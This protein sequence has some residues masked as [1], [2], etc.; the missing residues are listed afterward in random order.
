MEFEI[1][2]SIPKPKGR[3][4]ATSQYDSVLGIALRGKTVRLPVGD[5][6]SALKVRGAIAALIRNRKLPLRVASRGAEVY[7]EY[8]DV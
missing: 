5:A 2:D 4:G 1:V 6:K 8:K 7:L 3:S